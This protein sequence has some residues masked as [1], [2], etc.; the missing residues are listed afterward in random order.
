MKTKSECEQLCHPTPPP[1]PPPKMYQCNLTTHQCFLCPDQKACPGGLPLGPCEAGCK[2]SKHGPHGDLIGVW[3]GLYIQN[4][5]SR[6]EIELVL[7]TTSFTMYIDNVYH[8]TANV[9]S[10]GADVMLMNIIAGAHVGFKF[11]TIFQT[12]SGQANGLYEVMT[13]ARGEMGGTFPQDYQTPM[14]TLGMQ[15]MVLSKCTAS[16]CKFNQ[17]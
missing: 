4:A 3:R 2:H 16:Q 9:T 15:E 7:N 11:G 1:T 17:P 13:L 8:F 10:L 6:K 5:Y 12:A 14:E